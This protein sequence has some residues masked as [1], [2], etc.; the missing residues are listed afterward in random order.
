MEVLS[1][2]KGIGEN[3]GLNFL[4]E[5]GGRMEMY[6][7]DKKLIAAYGLDPSTYQSGKD[8]NQQRRK[9]I[10]FVVLLGFGAKLSCHQASK[11][12]DPP[13]YRRVL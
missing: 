13:D 8:Q 11:F 12:F 10:S 7:N 2:I 3:R 1:A 6:E 9:P 4:I 5:M